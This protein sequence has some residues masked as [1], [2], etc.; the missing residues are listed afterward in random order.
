MYKY[1]GELRVQHGQQLE[2]GISSIFHPSVC[3]SVRSFIRSFVPLRVYFV[4][5]LN[6]IYHAS[7]AVL[8]MV[9][10]AFLLITSK[11]LSW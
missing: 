1:M 2:C 5:C 4:A 11:V 3:P 6:L 10:P 7:A 8:M 9:V